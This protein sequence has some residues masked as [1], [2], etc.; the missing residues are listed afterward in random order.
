[1]HKIQQKAC[2]THAE[3]YFSSTGVPTVLLNIS[4]LKQETYKKKGKCKLRHTHGPS[5]RGSPTFLADERVHTLL[6]PR[7][8]FMYREGKLVGPT[9]ISEPGKP[10]RETQRREDFRT[11]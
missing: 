11:S 2:G 4:L 3:T 6:F 9:P 10:N 5:N 7:V 8:S 1:M